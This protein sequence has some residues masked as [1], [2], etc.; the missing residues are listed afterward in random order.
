M[1]FYPQLFYPEI[2]LLEN[3]YKEFFQEH[4]DLCEGTYIQM[5]HKEYKEHC[6]S[7]YTRTKQLFKQYSSKDARNR[8]LN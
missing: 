1:E 3:G 4:P 7:K 6:K 2:Y 8:I 5:E